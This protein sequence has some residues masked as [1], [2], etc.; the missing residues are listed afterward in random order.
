MPEDPV[1]EVTKAHKALQALLLELENLKAEVGRYSGVSRAFEP[2]ADAV[3]S[4]AGALA[5]ACGHFTDY[6][7]VVAAT[8][9]VSVSESLRAITGEVGVVQRALEETRKQ[10]AQS[11]ESVSKLTE[12]VLTHQRLV[13]ELAGIQKGV[14]AADS[15]SKYRDAELALLVR[16]QCETIA[17]SS[18][19][20]HDQ[21]R[22]VVERTTAS[23]QSEIQGSGRSLASQLDGLLAHV[24]AAKAA[25]SV[26][27]T[28]VIAGA[29]IALAAS[30]FA[31][32]AWRR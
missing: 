20:E 15:A 3:R 10:L 13:E 12:T 6:A 9:L 21:T 25:T 23:I 22:S 28:L 5:A 29:L 32:L 8:D 16:S 26:L 19:V 27:R 2:A 17:A 30:V 7:K 18:T 1:L 24:Q 31:Y 4:A 11:T 14:D